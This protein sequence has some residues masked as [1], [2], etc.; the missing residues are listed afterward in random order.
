MVFGAK[1]IDS[2]VISLNLA[3]WKQYLDISSVALFF[4]DLV[5][6]YFIGIVNTSGY[7][8]FHTIH[9]VE[10]IRNTRNIAHGPRPFVVVPLFAGECNFIFFCPPIVSIDDLIVFNSVSTSFSNPFMSTRWSLC[11]RYHDIRFLPLSQRW[12][13]LPCVHRHLRPP[14]SHSLPVFLLIC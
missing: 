14:S 6:T 8:H 5:P 1:R 12:L 11:H 13:P 2:Y 4:N 10:S 7:P 9:R 3:Y